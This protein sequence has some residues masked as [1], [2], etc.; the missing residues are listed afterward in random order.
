MRDSWQRR[1]DRAAQLAERG[2]AARPLL[3]TYGRLLALQQQSAEALGGLGDRLTGSLERDLFHVRRCARAILTAVAAGGPP[4]LAEESAHV[5][6]G[7]ELSIDALL[8][9]GWHAP[10]GHTFFTKL[11][12]QPYAGH[13]ASNAIQPL[14]RDLP[15][16]GHTCPFCGGVPQLSILQNSASAEGGARLLQCATC[17]TTWPAR[18]VLCPHCDEEDERRLGYFRSEAF[19]HLRVDACDTCRHYLK[20][21]DLT[22]LGLAVPLVDEVA[23]APLDLW[24]IEQ[25]YEKIEP[26]LMGL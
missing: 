10:S 12:L 4:N 22:R 16:G 6:D 9:A 21:V 11:I 26:N 20:T 5:L 24:A 2:D 3:L 15:E 14:G 23:A 7:D 25:G 1:I 19:D 8:L 13:L 18:R 17:F